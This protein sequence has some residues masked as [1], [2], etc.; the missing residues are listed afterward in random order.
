MV[1]ASRLKLRKEYAR[2]VEA[3]LKH[4]EKEIELAGLCRKMC[5]VLSKPKFDGKAADP[6]VAQARAANTEANELYEEP[7]ELGKKAMD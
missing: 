5:T 7:V 3:R 2:Y 1:K 4:N 6:L